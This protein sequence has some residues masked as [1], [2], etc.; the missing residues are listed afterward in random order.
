LFTNA[1]RPPTFIVEGQVMV[2]GLTLILAF[3]VIEKVFYPVFPPANNATEVV[4]WLT[5]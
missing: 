1:L 3:G 4:D 2:K 5:R